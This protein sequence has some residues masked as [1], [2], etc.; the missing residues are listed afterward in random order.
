MQMSPCWSAIHMLISFVFHG[1]WPQISDYG[2]DFIFD[3]LYQW[4]SSATMP[5]HHHYSKSNLNQILRSE[6]NILY[7]LYPSN[8]LVLATSVLFNLC[9]VFY[10]N[11]VWVWSRLKTE[12]RSAL[13]ICDEYF[14]L[15]KAYLDWFRNQI[16][17]GSWSK[18][19][20]KSYLN[21]SQFLTQW[22]GLSQI[23]LSLS[24]TNCSLFH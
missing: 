3:T 19:R 21:F 4:S 16:G 24:L 23:S 22:Q 18:E 11:R 6:T 9:F 7:L 8:S 17:S 5:R 1:H 20:C 2:S 12:Q 10:R 14:R 15:T 13:W